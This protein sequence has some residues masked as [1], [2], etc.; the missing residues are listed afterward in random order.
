MNKK[1][2]KT[3]LTLTLAAGLT[4]A[5]SSTV[6]ANVQSIPNGTRTVNKTVSQFFVLARQ[7]ETSTG[8]LGLSATIDENGAETSAENGLDA[9]MIKNTEWGATAMLATSSYGGITDNTAAATTTG[10]NSGIYQMNSGT[11]YVAGMWNTE[12]TYNSI[13]YNANQKYWD[14][15]LT[16]DGYINGDGTIETMR[17]KGASSA[18]FVNSSNQVFNRGNSGVFSYT[19]INGIDRSGYGS[20]ASVV[21]GL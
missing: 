3:L 4:C 10:N 17:W 1:I 13:L 7:M 14:K 2:T 6:H 16:S 9:H 8:P 20:R 18:S 5:V 19:I 12:N 11:E 21:C 15:Y